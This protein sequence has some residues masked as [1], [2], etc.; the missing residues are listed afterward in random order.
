MYCGHCIIELTVFSP[1]IRSSVFISAKCISLG[2]SRN[3]TIRNE[4]PSSV[5]SDSVLSSPPR[6]KIFSLDHAPHVMRFECL[7]RMGTRLDAKKEENRFSYKLVLTFNFHNLLCGLMIVNGQIA[8][9]CAN[10]Q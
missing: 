1:G 6:A 4:S 9:T 7:P 8:T 10:S 3:G 5:L 2:T